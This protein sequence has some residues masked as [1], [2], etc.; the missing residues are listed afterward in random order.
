MRGLGQRR[1][2]RIGR[3]IADVGIGR[4][5]NPGPSF[6]LVED[7][8]ALAHQRLGELHGIRRRRLVNRHQRRGHLHDA[9]FRIAR[10]RDTAGQ[11]AVGQ[12][13][14][15]GMETGIELCHDSRV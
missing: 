6:L 11:A 10:G 15:K 9:A 3:H 4:E 1:G 7:M 13:R 8:Q 14:A 5:L 12:I 2:E